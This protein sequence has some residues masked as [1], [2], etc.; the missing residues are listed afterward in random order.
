[1]RKKKAYIVGNL[2]CAIIFEGEKI[3]LVRGDREEVENIDSYVL[4]QIYAT[5]PELKLTSFS[6]QDTLRQEISKEYRKQDALH[7]ALEIMDSRLSMEYRQKTAIAL[8]E[9]I[10]NDPSL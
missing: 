1:M 2:N 10:E 5:R 8:K 9:V 6:Q 4:S 3:A 7:M